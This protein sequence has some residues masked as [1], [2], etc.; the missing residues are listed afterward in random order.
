MTDKAE[1]I[2]KLVLSGGGLRGSVHLGV[3]KYLEEQSV[4]LNVIAG[5]SIGSLIATLYTL[6]YTVQELETTLN[7]FNYEQYQS[8]DVNHILT[9]FGLDSFA[10]IKELLASLFIA[11]GYNP[12][13]TFKDLFVRTN[14]HLIMNAVCLNTHENTFFD[15]NLTPQ[16]PVLIAIHASMSL[17]II[18][19]SVKYD[20]LTYTDGGLLD[21]L[22]I[23]FPLFTEHPGTVLAI[24]LNNSFDFSVKDIKTIDHYA[25]HLFSTLYHAYVKALK[26]DQSKVHL[27]AIPTPGYNT[28][29]LSLSLS[30]KQALVAIGYQK[31]KD[32]FTNLRSVPASAPAEYAI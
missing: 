3:L 30:D 4:T 26:R 13:I 19:G 15:H 25:V 1:K 22:I 23:D 10:K 29:D 18:F 31:T 28:F 5:T 6:S 21:N 32:Y 8:I 17:P 9:H 11:K 12:Y 16:M 7:V 14:K 20:G 24:N 2:D 27:I